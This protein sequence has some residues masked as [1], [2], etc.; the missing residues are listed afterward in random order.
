VTNVSQIY[1]GVARVTAKAGKIDELL[2]FLRWDAEVSRLEAG[3]LRF[4]VWPDPLDTNT[5]VLSEAYTD[6]DAFKVHQ[7][8]E[9]FRR[10]VA[11]I[12]P[13]MVEK[14]EFIVAFGLSLATNAVP[15]NP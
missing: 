5:V 15:A 7:A 12:V 3:T 6:S 11:D 4:D 2:E 10:F 9:P 14:V 13:N 8:A 1:G